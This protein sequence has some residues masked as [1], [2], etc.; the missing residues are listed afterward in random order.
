LNVDPKEPL[1]Y[2]HGG[3]GIATLSNFPR[4]LKSKTYS[5]L[6]QD[7]AVIF[8]DYRGTGFSEPTLCKT[9]SDTLNVI[10]SAVLLSTN[11]GLDRIL[12]GF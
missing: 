1:L 3:P 10:S 7:H 12:F 11:I 4:Y 8:F 5:Q 2:L 9:I 6:R